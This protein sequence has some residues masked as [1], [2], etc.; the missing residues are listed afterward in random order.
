[1]FDDAKLTDMFQFLRIEK[2]SFT[3]DRENWWSFI[4]SLSQITVMRIDNELVG[5]YMCY[6]NHHE[7][8]LESLAVAKKHRGKGYSKMLLDHFLNNNTADHYSLHVADGNF[9]ALRLYEQN[10]FNIVGTEKNFYEDGSL[11]FVLQRNENH[12]RPRIR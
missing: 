1:M 2:E 8:Y 12:H 3:C 7:Y 6:G 11:A 4:M 10:G 9:V 5:Y